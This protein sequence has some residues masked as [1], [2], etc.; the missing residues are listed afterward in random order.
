MFRD[1]DPETDDAA[2]PSRDVR[3]FGLRR[4]DNAAVLGG[5]LVVSYFQSVDRVAADLDAD[6]HC[7]VGTPVASNSGLLAVVVGDQ[8][9]VA[10]NTSYDHAHQ[11]GSIPR[12]TD[13]VELPPTRSVRQ[14]PSRRCQDGSPSVPRRHRF[15]GGTR[16]LLLPRHS[17]DSPGLSDELGRSKRVQK[18]CD[19]YPKHADEMYGQLVEVWASHFTAAELR[20][21]ARQA[22][23]VQLDPAYANEPLQEAPQDFAGDPCGLLGQI[24]EMGCAFRHR[25]PSAAQL[26]GPCRLGL[27]TITCLNAVAFLV[28]VRSPGRLLSVSCQSLFLTIRRFATKM[29]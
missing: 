12:S 17:R 24:P 4:D 28:L 16:R 21:D 25:G 14:R 13:D 20:D 29:G 1:P 11:R 19:L 9:D 27:H 7:P 6:R 18:V 26:T 8:E 23:G 2:S 22:V 15:P 3:P 5:E 10:G